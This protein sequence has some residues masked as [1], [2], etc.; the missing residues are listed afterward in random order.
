MG[1]LYEYSGFIVSG[2]AALALGRRPSG[3]IK[4]LDKDKNNECVPVIGIKV[5]AIF[6]GIHLY[7]YTNQDGFTM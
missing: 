4:Y 5:W 2:T 3:F 1:Q 7:T 6:H